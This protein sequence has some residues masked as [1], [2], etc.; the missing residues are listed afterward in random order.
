MKQPELGRRIADLRK[1]QGLTQ[2]ELVEKC[3]V[4]VRTI[5]RIE[6]GEVTPRSYTIKTILGA[7]NAG[8]ED[9]NDQEPQEETP[10]G[11]RKVFL[12]GVNPDRAK[13]FLGRQLH[14][15]WV[16]GVIYFVF[17]FV[18]STADFFRMTHGTLFLGEYGYIT[19][20]LLVLGTYVVFMRGF[21][22]AGK[23]YNNT[24]L[25]VGA[26]MFIFLN[27]FLLGYDAISIVYDPLGYDFFMAGASVALG[28]VGFVFAFGVLKLSRPLGP[29]AYLSGGFELLVAFCFIT[30]FLSIPGLFLLVPAEIAG[31]I[32]LFKASEK[33]TPTKAD[34]AFV[35]EHAAS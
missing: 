27:I 22:V 18:E 15:A 26:L 13:S 2:E 5:Q 33:V 3:N 28:T 11:W 14:Y 21:F 12:T 32:L 7:M 19:I 17:G 10:V 35:G 6:S 24:L 9:F 30:V 25:R 16:F 1:S 34:P 8:L 4:S 23:L 29:V 20:K 31:I